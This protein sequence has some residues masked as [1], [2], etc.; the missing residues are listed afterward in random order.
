MAR[1]AEIPITDAVKMM[2]LVPARILRVDNRIGTITPGMD[3]DIVLF[4]ENINIR[5]VMGKGKVLV[6]TPW[7]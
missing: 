4:D 1:L 2:T 6:H 5:L 7:E 3:A